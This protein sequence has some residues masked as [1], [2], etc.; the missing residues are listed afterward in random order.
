M[1]EVGGKSA[2]LEEP[3]GAKGPERACF[4]QKAGVPGVR[5]A[6]VA[7]GGCRARWVGL[8]ED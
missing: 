7:E 8:P 2:S 4:R 5:V 3:A 6:M 1:E